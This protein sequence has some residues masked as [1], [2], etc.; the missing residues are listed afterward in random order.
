[1]MPHTTDT[2]YDD[3]RPFTDEQAV[4]AMPAAAQTECLCQVMHYAY[5]EMSPQEHRTILAT[6]T[7]IRDFIAKAVYPAV[8]RLFR[9]TTS[10]VVYRGMGS[11]EKTASYLFLSNHRDIVMD[12]V[13]LNYGLFAQGMPLTQSAIGNNLVPN[14]DLLLL[15]RINKNFIV[16]RDLSPRETLAF[17]GKLARYI[18]HVIDHSGDSV[19][20]AHREGRAKDGNDA[21]AAGV[22]KM[23][24]MGAFAGEDI[25]D[26][27]QG[28]HI[29]PMA[30][31]YQW[32]ATDGL[33]V[34]E[35]L[36]KES[37][38]R[39]V[40]APGEDFHSIVTGIAG[41]KGAVCVSLGRELK[42]EFEP[43]RAL[44]NDV[45]RVRAACA[46][47]DRH[48]HR[49]YELFSTHYAAADLLEGGHKRDFGYTPQEMLEFE[50]H[51]D[52]V[53]GQSAD[54]QA[55]RRILLAM[56]ANPVFNKE[57]AEKNEDTE[58]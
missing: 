48:I 29:V 36:A 22:M 45:R 11:L 49:L 20:L 38:G 17:S 58:I 52:Q 47:V 34:R 39:Y 44:D 26:V 13:I 40:K 54:P 31:S 30:I 27:L 21:T 23:L 56:Y 7:S 37:E 6:C 55:A 12:S 1:M 51:L 15:S 4:R 57:K 32:D 9:E 3:I 28:L 18:R 33:K 8:S 43:L 10:K 42:D 53:A 25:V 41:K 5:P 14:Q 50:Q 24:T 35:L 19:W 2:Q 16:R 46:I